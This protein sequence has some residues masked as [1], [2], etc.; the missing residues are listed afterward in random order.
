MKVKDLIE[1]LKKYN[2][3][4]E[5]S[6]IVHCH[7]EQFSLTWGGEGPETKEETKEVGFYVDRLCGSER[8]NKEATEPH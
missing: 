7:R 5:T 4:A 1:E 8:E 3:E 6:V 2:P